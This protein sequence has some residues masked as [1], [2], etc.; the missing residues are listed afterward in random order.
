[1]P[2]GVLPDPATTNTLDLQPHIPEGL[3]PRIRDPFWPV[4][5]APR[6][7][8]DIEREKALAAAARDK[9]TG[10]KWT[11]ARAT[12]HVG[13]YLKTPAGYNALVNNSVV[14]RADIVSLVYDGK[15]YRW[16]VE[17]VSANGIS[18][19]P[20][21]WVSVESKPKITGKDRP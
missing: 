14:T 19:V 2:E 16:K 4:G 11:E 17:S 15:L 18:F 20:L 9:V 6:S 3:T 5:Y 8:A 12:L 7:A 13:G 1:L 21:D 10:P